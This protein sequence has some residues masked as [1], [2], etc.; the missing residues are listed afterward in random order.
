MDNY[1]QNYNKY[2]VSPRSGNAWISAQ[3]KHSE[4]GI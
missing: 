4:R 3:R 2:G 1:A